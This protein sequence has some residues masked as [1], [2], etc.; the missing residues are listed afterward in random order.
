MGRYTILTAARHE[1]IKSVSL[2]ASGQ[3]RPIWVGLA[4]SAVAAEVDDVGIV[5]ETFALIRELEGL[6]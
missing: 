5:D 3:D 2:F 1:L 4:K 6:Q